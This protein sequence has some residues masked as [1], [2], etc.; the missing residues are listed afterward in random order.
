MCSAPEGTTIAQIGRQLAITRQGASK[1]VASLR[2]RDRDRDR[3]YVTVTA[4]P[5]NGREKTV[6]LTP[7]AY[8]YLAAHR[9]AAR[10][11]ERQLQA[12]LG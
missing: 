5:T 8:D 3:G 1:I 4:S 9:S 2:D 12:E 6:Q 10:G 7:R 11:I